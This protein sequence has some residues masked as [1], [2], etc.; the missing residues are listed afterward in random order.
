MSIP[1]PLWLPWQRFDFRSGMGDAP[2]PGAPASGILLQTPKSVA[3]RQFLINGARVIAL[4][5]TAWLQAQISGGMRLHTIDGGAR[6]IDGRWLA[7]D[8][9]WQLQLCRLGQERR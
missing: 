9:K 8:P 6:L 3:P 7:G 5:G 1:A 4:S 2:C